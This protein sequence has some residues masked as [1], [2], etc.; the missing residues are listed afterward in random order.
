MVDP[1]G[2]T[3]LHFKIE[4]FPKV[5]EISDNFYAKVEGFSNRAINSNRLP[6]HFCTR[7]FDRDIGQVS[8]SKRHNFPKTESG[9]LAS[10]ANQW[11]PS[12]GV[13]RLTCLNC[14]Y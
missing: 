1:I 3:Y 8:R 9:P 2:F 14:S 13:N 4:R 11:P 5:H 10:P 7:R 12:A 6:M